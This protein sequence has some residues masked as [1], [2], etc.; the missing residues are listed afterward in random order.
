VAALQAS[1]RW[2]P[3]ATPSGA[4]G[5]YLTLARNARGLEPAALPPLRW[6]STGHVLALSAGGRYSE[7]ARFA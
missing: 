5:L 3:G 7:I 4:D 1:I 6:R 2:P